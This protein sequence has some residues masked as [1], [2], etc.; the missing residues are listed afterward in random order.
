[1]AEIRASRIENFRYGSLPDKPV[2]KA[3]P[4]NLFVVVETGD[5]HATILDGDKLEPI[6][7]FATRFALHGGP[8]FSQDA[9]PPP[10]FSGMITVV[11]FWYNFGIKSH[12]IIASR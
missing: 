10:I 7:R 3:D 8:K 2:F 1:M 4:Q 12:A 9:F 5:H 11:K 6:H